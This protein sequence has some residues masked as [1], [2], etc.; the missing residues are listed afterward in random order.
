MQQRPLQDSVFYT[1][2]DAFYFASE[3]KALAVRPELREFDAVGLGQHLGINCAL[4]S[5]TLFESHY[6]G[7]AEWTWAVMAPCG[8]PLLPLRVMGKPAHPQ[9][10][11][12]EQF[13]QT[14]LKYCLGISARG[15]VISLTAGLDSRMILACL[16]PDRNNYHALRLRT[17]R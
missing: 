14:F 11:F 8:R 17:Q 9:S 12:Y 1:S 5:R 3:A 6:H 4:R 15:A 10:T 2:N 16:N 7:G 13:K